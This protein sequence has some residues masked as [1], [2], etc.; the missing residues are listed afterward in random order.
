MQFFFNVTM[1]RM[2]CEPS[3]MK[4]K[5][6]FGFMPFTEIEKKKKLNLCSIFLS[7][8]TK[9]E[10]LKVVGCRGHGFCVFIIT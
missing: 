8:H 2:L 6:V 4:K 5:I 9:V 3:N 7:C 10:S 1:R